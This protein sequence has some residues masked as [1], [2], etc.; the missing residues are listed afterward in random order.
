MSVLDFMTQEETIARLVNEAQVLLATEKFK[1]TGDFGLTDHEINLT[2]SA[3]TKNVHEVVAQG[4]LLD[5]ITVTLHRTTA[6][7]IEFC[8]ATMAPLT[9]R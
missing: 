5:Q 7:E 8:V 6:N 2:R 3:I 4:G 9:P 1:W